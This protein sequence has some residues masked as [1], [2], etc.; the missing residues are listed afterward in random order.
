MELVTKNI[1]TIT[2]YQKNLLLKKIH[3]F[4]LIHMAFIE[5]ETQSMTH[6]EIQFIFIQEKVLLKYFLISDFEVI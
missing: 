4:L 3:L 5:E 1:I 2:I 6:K